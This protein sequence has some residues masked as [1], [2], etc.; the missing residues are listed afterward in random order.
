MERKLE[1][2]VQDLQHL[3]TGDLLAVFLYGSAAAGEHVPD[4][5]DINVGVVLRHV[6]S[7]GL[8]KASGRIRAWQRLGFAT[9]VF[10]DT[11]FLRD[12]LDVFPIE[13]QD[14]RD[15]HRMLFGPDL[16]ADLQISEHH[17]RRQC[18]QELRGKLL[19]LR[20]T[21]VESAHNPE[22]L[23]T[24]LMLAIPSIVV[25]ARTL[26]LLTHNDNSGTTEAILLRA[27]D[28]LH[29]TTTALTTAWKMK[30]GEVRRTGSELERLYQ[31]VME[32]TEQLVR[33]TDAQKS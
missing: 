26:L 16:L 8:R 30:R 12:A 24:V 19:K 32:E 11:D 10:M 23:G 25:L 1:A 3:F 17:L 5:S 15:R 29:L 22:G 7:D 31:D 6:R 9:P 4:H 2:L 14:M 20:Q 21:Y 33:F 18:E 27:R 13:F 28:S